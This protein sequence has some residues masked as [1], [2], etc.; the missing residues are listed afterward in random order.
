VVETVGNLIPNAKVSS[1][2]LRQE[3]ERIKA[4]LSELGK[5]QHGLMR[6][7]RSE[8]TIRDKTEQIYK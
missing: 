5:L 3:A 6:N 4:Q 7:N 2:E 1:S 8:N